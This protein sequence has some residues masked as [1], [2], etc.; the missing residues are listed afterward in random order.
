MNTLLPNLGDREVII[1]PFDNRFEAIVTEY[2]H[3]KKFRAVDSNPETAL[4]KAMFL[5]LAPP[6]C[7]SYEEHTQS[8]CRN[9]ECGLEP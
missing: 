8:E 4:Q 9:H 5:A 6:L 7:A 1:R 2:E 3:G